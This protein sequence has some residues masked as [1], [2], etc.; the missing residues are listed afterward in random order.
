MKGLLQYFKVS[1][2]VEV[3]GQMVYRANF[4]LG[5]IMIAVRVFML[6]ALW[7]ALYAGRAEI[8]GIDLATMKF[9]TLASIIFEV[10]I[11]A[12]VEHAISDKIRDGSI[13]MVLTR[14][15]SYPVSVCIEQ[16]AFTAQNII[17]RVAPYTIFLLLS[18]LGF[19]AR[20]YL[21]PAFWLSTLL[22]Y[23]IMLF[24][25]MFFGMIAFW[26]MEI[27]GILE[28]R[29]AV[30]LVFSGSMVPLWFFPDWLFSVARFLPFQAMY[31]TPLSI[32]I[33]RISGPDIWTALAVQA[34]WL[35]VFFLLSLY[36]WGRSRQRVVVNGG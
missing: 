36:F 16:F 6:I 12:N 29:N 10:L 30:M 28:T 1:V 26:T 27:D 21:G 7:T 4:F 11:A 9:Y 14:P 18:G 35:A 22:A 15:A 17:L 8:D 3:R 32:L 23:F 20:V 33:G 2:R 31:N 19:G 13:A 24:Y 34:L 5:L 25:Q